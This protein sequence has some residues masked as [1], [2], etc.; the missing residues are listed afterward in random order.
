MALE[1]GVSGSIPHILAYNRNTSSY[2]QLR[3]YAA[4]ITL[5]GLNNDITFDDT[6]NIADSSSTNR[7]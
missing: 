5:Y 4:G 6:L 1:I 3:I 7:S 2:G